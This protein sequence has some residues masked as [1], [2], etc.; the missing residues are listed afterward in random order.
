MPATYGT[1]NLLELGVVR[2]LVR[3]VVI[4]ELVS[5]VLGE[6]FLAVRGLFF[7]KTESANWKVPWQQDRV[8]AV[9][10]RREVNGFSNWTKKDG[11]LHVQPP[12]DLLARMIAI[13]FHLDDSTE[14]NGPLRVIPGSHRSGFILDAQ[15]DEWK[16][17][18]SLTCTCKAGDAILMRPLL[19]HASSPATKTI[20]RRVI[21]VEFAEEALAGGL[22]WNETA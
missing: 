4:R 6:N 17:Q 19:L 20:P 1:R 16:K 10:E 9:R 8:I 7:D 21:H 12:V 14:E 13:R 22:R 18:S 2:E 3:S 11:V 5:P 15:L